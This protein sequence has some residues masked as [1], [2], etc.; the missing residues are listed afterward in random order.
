MVGGSIDSKL[1]RFVPG[2]EEGSLETRTDGILTLSP[3]LSCLFHIRSLEQRAQLRGDF[4]NHIDG[5]LDALECPKVYFENAELKKNGSEKVACWRSSASHRIRVVHWMLACGTSEVFG[6]ADGGD[7]PASE[8]TQSPSSIKQPVVRVSPPPTAAPAK[9]TT[10]TQTP[11]G[12]TR[13]SPENFPLGFSTGDAEV[14]RI[15]TTLRMKLLIQL[16][17]DQKKVNSTISQIQAVT[18]EKAK[19]LKQAKMRKHNANPPPDSSK[20]SR[21]KQQRRNR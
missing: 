6:D 10:S 21:G 15:L 5:Y 19:P 18:A 3:C 17:N 13:V 16:E 14:D 1:V 2:D 11:T 9:T 7:A 8:E 20:K 4:W 12:S